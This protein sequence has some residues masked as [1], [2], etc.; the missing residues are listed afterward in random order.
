MGELINIYCDESC[1][2]YKKEITHDNRYMVL[3]G[4]ICPDKIK[5]DVFERIKSIKTE[6][7]LTASSEMK[8]TKI[9]K[10]KLS[11][12]RDL[13][14]YFF[15]NPDLKF[16][17]LIVDK[18]QLNHNAFNQTH[19]D[20]Y[21][22]MYWQM[23]G[24]LIDPVNQYHIYLDIKDTQGVYKVQKLQKYLC[25]MHYDFDKTIISRIQEIRSHEV[26]IM[27]IIDLLI[28]AVSYA[29]RYHET[30]KS[31]AKNNIVALVQNRSRLNLRGSTSPGAS[32]FNLFHW[33]GQ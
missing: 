26:G 8:W 29:N 4:I 30:G 24:R 17:A 3:G 27:Q 33:Q 20:F 32:K 12:Y 14:H 11:A 22:K 16:R 25:N 15:D 23:L 6:H 1:H 7:G 10:P 2:L 9:S 31:E 19:D 21:Y 13:I 5:R 28:G 18:K